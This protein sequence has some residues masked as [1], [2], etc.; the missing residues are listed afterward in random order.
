[1]STQPPL[2]AECSHGQIVIR[3]IS[4]TQLLARAL[5]EL[6]KPGESVALS[7]EMGAGK[8]T[9]V[10]LIVGALNGPEGHVAS[11][12]FS[13]QN[14][15]RLPS[16]ILIEHW[17]LYRVREAPLELL[18]DKPNNAIRLIEWPE[19]VSGYLDSRTFFNL[20]VALSTNETGERLVALNG[21]KSA[22]LLN[23]LNITI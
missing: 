11:P 14:E 13:L 17:D 19:R 8:T 22:A 6:L 21:E 3:S 1:M 12:S 15:Y 16:G 18:E 4:D 10:R 23:R 2:L 5:A 7:G 9:L 20:H